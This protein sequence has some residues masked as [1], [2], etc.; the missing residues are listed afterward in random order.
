MKYF[1]STFL[2]LSLC[3]SG[4]GQTTDL[5]F[6]NAGGKNLNPQAGQQGSISTGFIVGG[7]SSRSFNPGL[8]TIGEVRI[9]FYDCSPCNKSVVSNISSTIELDNV[10]I[11]PNPANRHLVVDGQINSDY[12]YSIVNMEG[13]ILKQGAFRT[14]QTVNLVGIPKGFYLI[15]ILD[16]KS[17]V[18]YQEKLLIQ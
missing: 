3:I 11:Y 4:W 16:K 2:L 18:N 15:E 8:T 6:A 12:R 1:I 13:K 9:G 17:G 5:W 14:T 10:K 7:I